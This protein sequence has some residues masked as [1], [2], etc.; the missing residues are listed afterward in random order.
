M[1]VLFHKVYGTAHCASLWA[2]LA[3]PKDSWVGCS[4]VQIPSPAANLWTE[5]TNRARAPNADP[6]FS[7]GAREQEG[8]LLGP[9]T[10]PL[11]G[12]EPRVQETRTFCISLTSLWSF[13][14]SFCFFLVILHPVDMSFWSFCILL[15]FP[16]V[17]LH[18]VLSFWQF[19]IFSYL[20]GLYFF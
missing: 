8:V 19:Y 10:R 12:L 14:I 13:C 17:I 15:C 1:G 4:P 2:T 18:L 16:L 7:R 6:E 3:R 9:P 20:G 11:E 5:Q